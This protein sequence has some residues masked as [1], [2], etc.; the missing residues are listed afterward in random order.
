MIDVALPG[1]GGMM[2]LPGRWCSCMAVR[3]QGRMALFDCGEGTQIAL[4][5]M[6]WGARA[7]DLIALT[8]YH[9]DHVAGLPGLLLLAANSGRLEPVTI[10]GPP[11]LREVVAGLRVIAPVLPFEVHCWEWQTGERATVLGDLD[12]SCAAGQH[13]LPCLAYR[14]ALARAPRFNPE[15]ARALGVPLERWRELQR[16]Q[17]VVWPGGRATP[18]DVLGP[19]RRGL[20]VAYLTDTLARF[21]GDVD[22]LVCEATYADEADAAKAVERGHMLMREAAELARAAG[23]RAL[24]LTHF[25]PALADPLAYAPLARAHFPN[26]TIGYDGLWTTLSFEEDEPPPS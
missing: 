4:R 24:W 16:G 5:A 19:P 12:L 25:S 15:R 23:A 26:T 18:A 3:Y 2:P 1:T 9:A 17:E 14:L 6:G 7:L 22:L 13:S 11:G 20:A 10:V 8:H 21:V